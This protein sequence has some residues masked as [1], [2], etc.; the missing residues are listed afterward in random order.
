MKISSLAKL[1]V[2]L[3]LVA[4]VY[5]VVDRLLSD[6][7]VLGSDSAVEED[8][9]EYNPAIW[10]QG[11]QSLADF[12]TEIDSLISQMTISDKVGQLIMGEIKNLTPE[13][14]ASYRLGGILNGGGT[15]PNNDIN[16]TAND[17]LALAQ[18]F[19]NASLRPV[20]DRPGIPVI[21][22]SD[23]VHGHNNLVGSTLF[24]HNIGLGATGNAEL[25]Y[26]IGHAVAR[27]TAASGIFL[28]FAPTV[29]VPQDDRWG[30]SYEGF[31]EDP[32]LVSKLAVPMLRGL[33]GDI[34]ES[35][36]IIAPDRVGATAKHFVGD[37][38]TTDGIDRG[39]TRI[40]EQQLRDTHGQSYVDLVNNNV[41]VVMASFNS[42]NGKRLHGHRYLLTDILKGRLGFQGFVVGDWDGHAHVAGCN[43]GSC[44]QAINAGVDMFMVPHR[45]KELYE[46]TLED[47]K[48][49]RIPAE[50][51]D[52]AVRRILRVKAILGL[53][54][55]ASP[56]QRAG[57]GDNGIIG[58]PSHRSIARQAV[59]ESLVLLKNNGKTLPLG[60]ASKVLVAGEAARSMS[61]QAGGWSLNWQGNAENKHFPGATTIYDG[62]ARLVEEGGGS[63]SYSEDGSFDDK[64]DVAI[65]VY[66]EKPYA[67]WI[68]DRKTLDFDPGKRKGRIELLAGL[69]AQGVPVVSVF[70]SGRPMWVNEEIN[71]S[72]A[73]V[74]AWLPGSEG[75]GVADVLF[76][77]DGAGSD[78]DFKGKLTFSWPASSDHFH[79]N[80]GQPD[81]APLFAFGY[82]LDY[83]SEHLDMPMLDTSGASS[84]SSQI[85]Q[86][87]FSG[88]AVDPLRLRLV[89]PA[90]D[91]AFAKPA[92][93]SADGVL[94]AKVFDYQRQEDS[95][96]LSF[97]GEGEG[98]WRLELDKGE[99]L[100]WLAEPEGAAVV[101]TMRVVEAA[102]ASMHFTLKCGAPCTATADIGEI[103]RN[104]SGGD[105]FDLAL[106]LGCLSK[107]GANL[108]SITRPV[109]LHS[110][111][112]WALDLSVVRL[113][114]PTEHARVLSCP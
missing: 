8:A 103:L 15:F 58:H 60:A 53:F 49:G 109:S 26:E 100:D 81:Y 36:Q 50:R 30:R 25:M 99:R 89:D 106:P 76:C 13:D 75:G 96:S 55:G 97:S 21:W 37:G 73:F 18:E 65:V 45:W 92:T 87:L 102:N 72:D 19:H 38:G 114:M 10:P 94:S 7:G 35:S 9:G 85:G 98:A 78:C 6:G 61:I 110:A 56:S 82:G 28:T 107:L 69:R 31:S 16:S 93:V 83:G 70:I 71:A 24:P 88:A 5:Y 63:A 43:E 112:K 59:R 48:A 52:D 22:G 64:P 77:S 67:E 47:A 42:W 68:G 17:W 80:V 1:V 101:M 39:D 74:A 40:S 66:G 14:V 90:G 3:V 46:N 104:E 44:Y 62:I 79:N 33:Q 51:L 4:S 91:V 32:A 41:L 113:D 84:H 12:E 34:G 108:A 11:S 27:E 2:F 95:Q 54:H 57:A 29:A 23:A 20:D 105:W 111:D 86:L